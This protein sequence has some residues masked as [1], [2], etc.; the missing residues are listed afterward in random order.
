MHAPYAS[1]ARCAL[2][3]RCTTRALDSV[4]TLR[5]CARQLATADCRR[6]NHSP[7]LPPLSSSSSS[8][9]SSPL[10]SQGLSNI[11]T[12]L[13][14]QSHRAA[15]P[16]PLLLRRLRQRRNL[17]HR[18]PLTNAHTREVKA[19]AAACAAAPRRLWRSS[20]AAT[21]SRRR[22]ARACAHRRPLRCCC[23]SRQTGICPPSRLNRAAS[24]RHNKRRHAMQ[25]VWN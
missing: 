9:S 20:C 2:A 21:A 17:T 4:C 19:N 7:P 24:L 3:A 15:P 5:L 11:I 16:L 12:Q 13:A 1:R 23:C 18:H 6:I 25:R 10:S 8:S 14:Q 22:T